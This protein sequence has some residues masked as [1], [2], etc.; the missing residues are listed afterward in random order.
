MDSRTIAM[1]AHVQAHAGVQR[2][3]D[4]EPAG[5]GDVVAVRGDSGHR[6]DLPRGGTYLFRESRR[7][8][9]LMMAK[10]PLPIALLA[11]LALLIASCS[12]SQQ[13]STPETTIPSAA[14]AVSTDPQVNAILQ[15]SCYQCHST[16]GT[17]PW[18]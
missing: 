18:Y 5:D 14:S 10:I 7:L 15:S 6:D 1:V 3:D 2:L 13:T 9:G 8:A 11:G 4:S 16:G 17:A 12:S